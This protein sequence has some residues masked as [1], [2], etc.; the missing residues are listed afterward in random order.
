MKAAF[1][2]ALL[3]AVMLPA[4]IGFEPGL[5]ETP[6]MR[7][8]GN[9]H[10]SGVTRLSTDQNNRYLVSSS[11]DKTARIWDLTSGSLLR[12]LRPRIDAGSESFLY[13]AAMSP[14][15]SLVA[16]A[17]MDRRIYL[18]ER[19]SGRLIRTIEQPS[20]VLHLDYSA[21]GRYLLVALAGKKGCHIYE[22][23][24]YSRVATTQ[25]IEGS[26]HYAAMDARHQVIT[27]SDDGFVRL[28]RFDAR[29]NGP[30]RLSA[31]RRFETGFPRSAVFSPDGGHI[32]VGFAKTSRIDIL[33]TTNLATVQQ[34]DIGDCEKPVI[35]LAWSMDGG[36]LYGGGACQKGRGK[37]II[38][39]WSIKDAGDYEDYR[40][41]QDSIEHMVVLKNGAVV[42]ASN[43]PSIGI[44][45]PTGALRL[46]S[47]PE[48]PDYRGMGDR[49]QVNED[50]S[51]L[52]VALERG[53]ES[54][55]FALP[56]RMVTASSMFDIDTPALSAPLR[57]TG[58]G[59][60]NFFGTDGKLSVTDWENHPSPKLNG[61][62]LTL[63]MNDL[64]RSLAIAPAEDRFVLGT[65]STVRCY[66]RLGR[67]LWSTRTPG[68][69]WNLNIPREGKVV[70][71]ALGDGTVRW[72]RLE[73]GVEL[74]ALLLNRNKTSW[75]IWSP[76]GFFDAHH[77]AEGLVGWHL[78]QGKDEEALFFPISRFFDTFYRPDLI[79]TILD[80]AVSDGELLDRAGAATAV[81]EAKRLPPSV[82]IRGYPAETDEEQ[83]EVEIDAVDE[84]GGIDEIRVSLNGKVIDNR[85]RGLGISGMPGD[86][87][88]KTKRVIIDL[89][90][91]EN[92]LRAV[93]YSNDRMEGAAAEALIQYH[94]V[95]NE[96][97]L[98]IIAIGINDYQNPALN[99]DFA[100]LDAE[101]II[102]K[103]MTASAGLFTGTEVHQVF[104]QEAT[105]DGILRALRSIQLRPAD[106]VVLFLAG[107]GETDGTSW[108]F[109]PYDLTYPE[110]L[111]ELQEKG[112]SSKELQGEIV[113]MG[114]GKVLVLLD[115]CKSGAALKAFSSRGIQERQALARLV[116]ASGAHVVAASTKEQAASEIAEIGHGVFTYTILQGMNGAADGSPKDGVVTVRELLSFIEAQLPTVSSKYKSM[117]QYP[118]A[119]SMGNDFPLSVIP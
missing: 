19:E 45:F 112:L 6:H 67:K 48:V 9:S 28:Y 80:R 70:L 50:G 68:T 86:K 89:H 2:R 110:R 74:A 69:V 63:D 43:D 12:T 8:D 24:H 59:L 16:T 18:F 54:V 114:A 84:G 61:R 116:R 83:I 34:P 55:R 108:Y 56:I 40:V 107:H 15:G 49:F 81:L 100:R 21:D 5:A 113:R 91:G 23:P 77:N 75:I 85:T 3:W 27:A 11:K 104:D 71:A 17:G 39:G 118:V 32:A 33:T 10:T 119:Y 1:C 47:Q 29:P 31:Q 14:D 111:P 88:R 25:D 38:R 52:Q 26:T 87:V 117:A 62:G 72:Y 79:D 105:K 92:H 93:G 42:F 35:A 99:L 103:F 22:T 37:T 102:S 109:V 96:S 101:G 65:E 73:D 44:L 78:N 7:I 58:T 98:H 76:L 90:P 95:K 115:S 41:A 36:S 106:E 51:V 64:S 46:L 20:A 94:A 57:K 82:A 66:D 60:L 97:V 4:C 13:A 30:L 53:Q